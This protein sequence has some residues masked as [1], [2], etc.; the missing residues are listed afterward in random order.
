M[1]TEVVEIPETLSGSEACENLYGVHKRMW[2]KW[3]QQARFIFNYVYTSLG[4]QAIIV[5]PEASIIPQPHWQTIKWNAAWLAADAAY[6]SVK[7]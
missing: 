7:Q 3:N 6:E 1:K 2:R 5:H 4:D